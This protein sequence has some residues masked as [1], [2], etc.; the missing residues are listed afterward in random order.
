M[1]TWINEK[2]KWII[3]VFAVGITVGLLA[4]DRLPEHTTQFPVG[5]INGEKLS[6][7]TFDMRLKQITANRSQGESLS[8]EQHAKLRNDVFQSFVREHLLSKIFE[9]T[10]LVA[11]VTE[12][13]QEISHNPDVVRSIV[14]QE[15]QQRLYIIQQGASNPEEANQR[16]QNYIATLPQFLLDTA[17][18][19]ESFEAWLKTPQAYEWQS[20][21]NYEMELKHS[22][23]PLKQLQLFV[24]AALHPTSLEASYNAKRRLTEY[25]LEVASVKASDF[26]RDHVVDSA[27]VKAYF[28]SHPDSFY[29]EKDLV[30]LQY[31]IIPLKPT[32]SD[33]EKVKDY[34]MTL[35]NQLADSS[36]GT[37]FE[38]LARISSEDLQ[39]AEQGG[40]LGDYTAKGVWVKE[41]EAV[42]FSLDSG[43]ISEPVRTQYGFHII[44]SH[45]KKLDSSDAELVKV[46]HILLTVT[47]SSETID[48]LELILEQ[49]K[50]DFSKSK[51]FSSS[52]QSNG[53]SVLESDWLTKEDSISSLGF[54]PGLSAYAFANKE[55]PEVNSGPISNVL[56]NKSYV[57]LASKK[58]SLKAG[59][60]SL[61]AFYKNIEESLLQKKAVEAA[62]TYL[63][64][65]EAKVKALDKKDS[66]SLD[67]SLSIDK[68]SIENL[69]ASIDSYVPGVGFG[70]ESFVKA[71]KGLKVGEWSSVVPGE[72]SAFMLKLVNKT[73]ASEETLNETVASEILNAFR[74]ETNFVFNDF[75][76][77][78][79]HSAK[80]QDNLDLYYRN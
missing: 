37:N 20:M 67:S 19:K 60:R 22:T 35:Y 53:L 62:A 6:H 12:M 41:F 52:V 61:S 56:K 46:S 50:V 30:K 4:M 44:K 15:A 73:E 80:I 3:V 59:T 45:G 16:V 23:I 72:S 42:A 29:I 28:Q 47:P 78:L 48:S 1:L 7:E 65:V 51:N 71:L 40:L 34:A 49:V 68:V 70:S 77:N 38:D 39:S 2:A 21:M 66:I 75:I 5:T 32:P 25:E 9:N 64:S 24:S 69:S 17:F 33:E 58:D 13:Q 79:E 54:I 36:T 11:S 18:N 26:N 43:A 55:R 76:N 57:F 74:F 10:G 27:E 14:S 63:K 8:D 31:A